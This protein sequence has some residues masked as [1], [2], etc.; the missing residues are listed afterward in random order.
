MHLI[1]QVLEPVIED[2]SSFM[3]NILDEIDLSDP[4]AVT[5][6]VSAILSVITTPPVSNSVKLVIH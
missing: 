4:A 1:L 3:N 2:T 5:S 6:S